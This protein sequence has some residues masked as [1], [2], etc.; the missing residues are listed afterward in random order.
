MEFLCSFATRVNDRI[1][2]WSKSRLYSNFGL[3]LFKRLPTGF[4][5]RVI[6]A[7]AREHAS[8]LAD[9]DKS[10]AVI[11]SHDLSA[12]GAPRVALV[13][14]QV[15]SE[16]GVRVVVVSA[17][18]GPIRSLIEDTA[19]KVVIDEYA[20]TGESIASEFIRRCGVAICN[21]VVTF[22]VAER[23]AYQVPTILY[24]HETGLTRE[25]L[26]TPSGFREA[27]GSPIALWAASA[28]CAES[29]EIEG[30]EIDVVLPCA[31]CIANDY[32]RG[33][34]SLD[35]LKLGVFGSLE[36]RKGQ[37]VLVEALY[38]LS[39]ET[40]SRVEVVV[41]GRPLEGAVIE[42]VAKAERELGCIKYIGELGPDRVI[43]EMKSLHGVMVPSR[44]EPLS[45]VAVEAMS[46][47]LVP[48]CTR[49]CGI[50]DF[51]VK[52]GAGLVAESCSA[53]EIA[54]LIERALDM[55]DSWEEMGKRSRALFDETFSYAG[56]KRAVI[57]RLKTVSNVC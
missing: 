50:S 16:H 52:Q 15:L 23:V 28:R 19:A 9:L 27:L 34:G 41:A 47:G 25:L 12:S 35:V 5:D 29:L 11:L 39:E 24:V 40:R 57:D 51:L 14:A 48:L 30:R 31:G 33:F 26:E 10:V 38:M 43:G 37:D 6:A 1:K 32:I 49:E 42:A 36:R 53:P 17:H 54:K 44:D 4:R 2:S 20:L 8:F 46:L 45:L 18:D 7:L 56:F 13:L 22:R 21:T 55:R 3:K